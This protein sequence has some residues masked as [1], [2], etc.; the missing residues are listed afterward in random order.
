MA[1]RLGM[2]GSTILS[3]YKRFHEL[4]NQGLPHIEIGEF[5]DKQ[6]YSS[7]LNMAHDHTITFGIH[8]PHFRHNSKYDLIEKVKVAPAI[9]RKMFE[10]EV[11]EAV[12]SG[13]TYILVH[14]PYFKG[15][16]KS[17]HEKIEEGLQFLHNLQESYGVT[18]VCEPK[19]GHHQSS[20]GIQYLKD[21]PMEVW[22]KYGLSIC[23]D[24]GD[25]MV[26]AGREWKDYISPLLPFTKVVHMHNV[27]YIENHYIWVPIHPDPVIQG[28][29]YDMQPCLELLAEG[30]DKYFIFEHTP[31]SHPSEEIVQE[32]ISWVKDIIK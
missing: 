23:I 6:A 1:H 19:L 13:A 7:F 29:A 20:A 31:H 26:A 12:Q 22:G 9:A 27:Q 3:N 25:Y 28:A 32:G 11:A 8:V 4:F 14:F 16:A 21:F 5:E 10:A 17:T 24:I 15:K 30:K 18:I 2:S